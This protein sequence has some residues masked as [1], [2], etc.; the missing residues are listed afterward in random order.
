MNWKSEEICKTIQDS[1][2]E[3]DSYLSV[4][5]DEVICRLRVPPSVLSLFCETNKIELEL[6][7]KALE[8]IITQGSP[9]HEIPEHEIPHDPILC[10]FKPYDHIFAPY[11]RR[12]HH[13]FRRRAGLN[14]PF[15]RLTRLK[16]MERLL[17][18]DV[19]QDKTKQGGAGLKLSD[20]KKRGE[21][22]DYFALHDREMC[23]SVC[24]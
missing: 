8:D 17:Q 18:S 16:L 23:D 11:T 10:H 15:D 3:I 1:G 6:D 24:E 4:Q 7:P 21:I 14:H 13:Y 9:A 12:V 22:H 19:E 20:M 2:M 5:E